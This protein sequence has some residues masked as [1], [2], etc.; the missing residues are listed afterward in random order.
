MSCLHTRNVENLTGE[1]H[2]KTFDDM[3]TILRGMS[4][5]IAFGKYS[6]DQIGIPQHRQRWFIIGIKRNDE[7]EGS[8]NEVLLENMDAA[9]QEAIPTKSD[10][11]RIA[12]G[13][14]KKRKSRIGHRKA[15]TNY[16][17]QI[18]VLAS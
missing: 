9:I 16:L 6:P 18:L 1:K 14:I 13:D 5:D 17:G 4:Y 7:L 8:E 2:A 3:R 10:F 11:E 15:G 12:G